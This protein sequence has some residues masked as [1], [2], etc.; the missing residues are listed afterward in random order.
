MNMTHY[1]TVFENMY[2][3]SS[4]SSKAVAPFFS[5]A[6]HRGKSGGYISFGGL[7][8]IGK[9]EDLI[10]S[11]FHGIN[12]FGERD[13]TRFYPVRPDGFTLDGVKHPTNY[14]VAI[15]SGT[16]VNRLPKDV[17]ERINAA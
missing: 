8:P 9:V 5:L 11:P 1:P 3:Q 14:T 2:S 12:Y 13:P 15:D 7:A 6:L 16:G 4:P 17:A 10:F